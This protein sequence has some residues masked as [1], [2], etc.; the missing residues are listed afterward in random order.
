MLNIMLVCCF[1]IYLQYF[2]RFQDY[3]INS[4]QHGRLVL[5]KDCC[6]S[7]AQIFHNIICT[8]GIF[9]DCLS[10]EN[11]VSAFRSLLE[12]SD[13]QAFVFLMES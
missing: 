9:L 3:M 2:V 6:N 4:M 5:N 13:R 10:S 1:T 7:V 8:T 11:I 12:T